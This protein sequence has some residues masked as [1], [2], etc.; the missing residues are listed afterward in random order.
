M[1]NDEAKHLRPGQRV[2][3]DRWGT[4]GEHVTEAEVM[5]VMTLQSGTAQVYVCPTGEGMPKYAFSQ[6]ISVA[7]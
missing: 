2:R 4:G 3:F 6:D 5:H 1:T 7:E